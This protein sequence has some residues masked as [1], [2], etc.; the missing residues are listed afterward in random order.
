MIIRIHPA[1][2]K[3]YLLMAGLFMIAITPFLMFFLLLPEGGADDEPTLRG[4]NQLA[5]P[6]TA[7]QIQSPPTDFLPEASSTTM[8]PPPEPA[9]KPKPTR[10]TTSGAK[11]APPPPPPSTPSPQPPPA[12]QVT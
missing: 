12:V 4:R 9:S 7:A 5:F 8:E 1:K 11:A 10:K 6:Y 2:I 3:K